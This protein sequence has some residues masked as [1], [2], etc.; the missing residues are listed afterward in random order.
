MNSL[1][2]RRGTQ[3]TPF[4]DQEDQ[5]RMTLAG[6]LDLKVSIINQ[7]VEN[8]CVGAGTTIA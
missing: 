3:E 6:L 5:A 2:Q 8:L 1:S 7:V 4:N